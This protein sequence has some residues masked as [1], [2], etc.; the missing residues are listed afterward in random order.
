MIQGKRGGNNRAF[1]ATGLHIFPVLLASASLRRATIFK[2]LLSY[3]C[4][5]FNYYYYYFYYYYSYD[6]SIYDT[7]F[8]AKKL[9]KYVGVRCVDVV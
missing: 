9:R 1:F 7:F 4:N 6:F 2:C 3:C 5:C 8:K